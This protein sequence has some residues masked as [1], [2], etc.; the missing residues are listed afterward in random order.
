MAAG[1]DKV[2][3]IGAGTMGTGIAA[4]S[5]DA[6]LDVVLLDV[7]RARVERAV[8][9]MTA[10]RAPMVDDPEAVKRIRTGTFPGDIASIGDADWVCEAIIEDLEAKRSLFELIERHRKPGS[11][12]TTNTSGIPL[13]AI[14]EHSSQE[15]RREV[16]VT[17]FFNPVKVMKL[18]ELIPASDTDPAVIDRLHAFLSERFAKGVVHAKDT[19]N[20][21]GNRIG[22]FW[23]LAGL[24]KAEAAMDDGLDMETIDALVGPPFGIPTTGLFGLIDLIGLDVMDLVAKNLAR[25]LPEADA[26][27]AFAE[28]PEAERVMLE[29][30]QLGRKTGGG[31]YR[32]TRHDDGRRT[33]ETFDLRGQTWRPA[34]DVMLEPAHQEP[35]NLIFADDPAGRFARDLMGA[36]FAYAADLVPEISN[37]IVNIDRAM[38][39][40]FG[41]R[42][43]PFE[44]MD[45]IGAAGIAQMIGS[46]GGRRPRMLEVLERSGASSFY[47]AD[48]AEQLGPDGGWHPVR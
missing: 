19:V 38:R 20:F 6:G 43:G 40:G 24:H 15:L 14:V 26:G 1:I 2:A 16:A 37:D 22:C 35:A 30:G 7:D 39:W 46:P 11:I 21:I 17:H 27:R 41:W 29:R 23:M 28:L 44:L 48:G 42:H 8:A 34:H 5:A 36:T 3:V 47:R 4:L 18:V 25:N 13:R 9:A 12:V 10:G 33:K 31:F 45:T 32:L